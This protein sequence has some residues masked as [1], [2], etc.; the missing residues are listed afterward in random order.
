MV[1]QLPALAI[2]CHD[3]GDKAVYFTIHETE[4]RSESLHAGWT[5]EQGA[6][7]CPVCSAKRNTRPRQAA[8]VT[9]NR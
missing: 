5:G 9:A 2:F 1:M 6:D 3:C 7:F 8:R 4:V